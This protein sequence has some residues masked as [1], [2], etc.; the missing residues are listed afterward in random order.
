[1]LSRVRHFEIPW[2]ITCQA[3]LSM[4]FSRQE[5][6]SGY[7]FPSPGDLPHPGTEPES[8]ALQANSLWSEPLYFSLKKKK[9]I[10]SL[11]FRGAMYHI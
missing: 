7:S 6:W 10:T 2:T 4:K 5:Y 9:H 1:M 3:S 11:D 8:P